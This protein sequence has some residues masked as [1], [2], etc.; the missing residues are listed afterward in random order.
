MRAENI[1]PNT[2][3][4]RGHGLAGFQ[5]FLLTRGRMPRPG[6]VRRE[7]VQAYMAH[8]L[9]SGPVS[10][11][12]N[13]FRSLHRWFRWLEEEKELEA[14]ANPMARMTAPVVP[15]TTPDVLAEEA[16][17]KILATCEG[18]SFVDRRDRALIRF[19][20]DTGAR[21]SEVAKMTMCARDLD[22]DMDPAGARL[23]G[24]GTKERVA[25]LGARMVRDLDRYLRVR[26]HHWAANH[27]IP[28]ALGRT[29]ETAPALWLG[30]RGPMTGSGVYQV[31]RARAKEAQIEQRV[32]AHLFRATFADMWL[33][34]DGQEGDLMA[35]AGWDSLTMLRRYTKKR[36]MERARASHKLRAPGDRV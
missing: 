28:V 16:L 1:A 26:G 4:D 6:A 19:L 5:R 2:I 3:R 31:V 22:L 32:F 17:K 25:A 18:T 14:D 21:R 36:R 10:T 23:V 33:S 24:K 30:K 9:A 11:A 8:L 20:I 27:R 29:G 35:L 12:N 15:E 34:S 13:R 7:Q